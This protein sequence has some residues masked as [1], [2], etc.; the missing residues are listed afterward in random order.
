M[1]V[2][3]KGNTNNIFSSEV[4]YLFKWRVIGDLLFIYNFI[5][6]Y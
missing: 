4:Y 3:G 6:N 5:S 2:V 1:R